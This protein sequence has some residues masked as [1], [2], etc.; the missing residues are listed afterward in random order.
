[1]TVNLCPAIPASASDADADATRHFD[2]FFNRWYLDPSSVGAIL[3]TLWTTTL[4]R[5]VF[6]T[7]PLIS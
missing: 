1:M 6:R 5:D 4:P 7:T 2:G 3:L